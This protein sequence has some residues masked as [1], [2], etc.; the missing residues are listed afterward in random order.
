MNA[1]TLLAGLA[2]AIALPAAA[3]PV[4]AWA[5]HGWAGQEDTPTTLQGTII[6]SSYTA[7]HGK[8]EI[9]AADQTRWTITLAPPTRMSARGLKAD[10][11][12][13][14]EKVTIIGN[15]NLDHRIMELKAAR[16]T[17]GGKTTDPMA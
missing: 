14:G 16:I 11:L 15:R 7:P 8:L 2:V 4:S 9:I 12:K 6:S 5:H 17:V 3:L 13:A 1:K 10:M